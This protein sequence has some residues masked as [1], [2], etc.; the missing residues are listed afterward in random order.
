MLCEIVAVG[1]ELLLGQIVDTNSAWIGE[2]LA[3]SGI[4][5]HR[6]TVV[7]DNRERMMA[8][9]CEALDRADA[10]IVTGGLGPTQD[11]IT[12]E[13][14]A[15]LMGVTMERDQAL[16]DRIEA[17]FA[18][19][20][21]KMPANNLRQ[22]DVPV[23]ATTMSEL[24][25]TAPG[26]ICPVGDKVLY[27]VP[28]VPWE[29]KEMLEGS[30]LPDLRRRAGA[31]SVIGSRTLRT[32][33]QSESGLAE[34]LAEEIDRLDLEGGPTLAFLASGMEGL[35]VRITAK[36]ATSVEVEAILDD[37]E[38]R[39]RG[40][41]GPIVFGMDGANMESVVLD[42]LVAQGLTLV[43]AESL[44]GGLIGSR[45]TDVPGSS[46]AFRG[47][48]VA[49]AGDIKREL[50][51]V[52]EGPVVSEEAVVAMATGVCR[53]LSADVSVAVTG[54][55]GPDP[56]DG[57]EPGTVWMATCVDGEVEAVRILFPFDRTRTRQFTV[58]SVLNLLRL[59]LLA[60]R[61][62]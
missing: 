24:P 56:Q 21:R 33:G 5:C 31:V 57:Q 38:A 42:E 50:L 20:G 59:R 2:Q 9:F 35:K 30:I 13:V 27:T 43:T 39:V 32:W 46:R 41:I 12:R 22:A 1:T 34:M 53:V 16:V 47:S 60:R 25:G 54:V 3:L 18:G 44:T 15:E 6:Y 52:P 29:M 4:D 55:A 48:V 36:A 37:E 58:I 28:G 40:V 26:L 14:V 45:L 7:G 8:A 61:G 51:G 11:D 17:R 62:C 23:G 19:R 10:V 49:Y